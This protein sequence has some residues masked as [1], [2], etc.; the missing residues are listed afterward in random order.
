MMGPQGRN[1][2]HISTLTEISNIIPSLYFANIESFEFGSVGDSG[3][4]SV[5]SKLL[6]EAAFFKPSWLV[7]AILRLLSGKKTCGLEF[8]VNSDTQVAK[9]NTSFEGRLALKGV[10]VALAL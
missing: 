2:V 4:S 6:I 7:A 3:S 9:D 10:N 1:Q 5:E 8:L